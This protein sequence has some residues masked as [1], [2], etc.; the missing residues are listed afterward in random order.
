M[1][2]GSALVVTARAS[3][4]RAWCGTQGRDVVKGTQTPDG[5]H[6][7][8]RASHSI[9][10]SPILYLLL[11]PDWFSSN[12]DLC[13]R[14]RCNTYPLQAAGIWAPSFLSH[15][16]EMTKALASSV[17]SN[18]S[19]CTRDIPATRLPSG[20]ERQSSNADSQAL[21][22][23]HPMLVNENSLIGPDANFSAYINP[24][25]NPGSSGRGSGPNIT[26]LKGDKSLDLNP[27]LSVGFQSC[28]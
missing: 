8:I 3:L 21:P 16:S 19:L 6:P 9:P 23:H 13:F 2:P 25:G 15:L 27:C 10:S 4:G 14:C 20:A 18:T 17:C 11:R 24:L 5:A 12:I 26:Y 28:T 1:A 7:R 22:C